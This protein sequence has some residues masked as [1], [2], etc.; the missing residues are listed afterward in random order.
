VVARELAIG[1]EAQGHAIHHA[2]VA[3][4]KAVEAAEREATRAVEA[5]EVAVARHQ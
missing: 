1:G 5:A 4:E 2:D 3:L